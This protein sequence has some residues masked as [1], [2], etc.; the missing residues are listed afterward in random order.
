MLICRDAQGVHQYLNSFV[1]Y[2]AACKKQSDAA[3]LGSPAVER[4]VGSQYSVRVDPCCGNYVSPLVV[5]EQKVLGIG[6]RR[7]QPQICDFHAKPVDAF[8]KDAAN[9][10]GY[11]GTR[12]RAPERRFDVR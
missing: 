9:T 2:Q 1:G 10:L 12:S 6:L 5:S 11:R 4:F 8:Y 3:A 7:E